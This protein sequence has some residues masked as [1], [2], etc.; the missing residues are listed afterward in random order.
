MSKDLYAILGVSKNSSQDEIKK[1]Y[2]KIAMKYHPDRNP[3]NKE[4]EAKF[5]EA[6]EAYETLSNPEKKQYYDTYGTTEGQN[7]GFGGGSP[8][9]GSGFEDIF[10]QFFGGGSPFGSSGGQ[11]RSRSMS[12]DGS[13][14][15]FSLSITLEEA[16]NGV[17]KKVS[18]NGNVGCKTCDGIGGKGI[19]TC[20]ICKGSG[21]IRQQRGFFI[22]ESTC[23]A[24]HGNGQTISNKCKDCDGDGRKV[25]NRTIEVKVMQGIKDGQKILLQEQGDAG[26]YGGKNGDLYILVNIQ[27]HKIFT[28]IENDIHFNITIPF[29]D[30]I[31]G[32]EIE[33]PTIDGKYEKVTISAGTQSDSEI[34]VKNK[35]VNRLNASGM[36]GN[37]ILKTKIETPV[38]LNKK[39]KELIEEFRTQSTE[40]NSPNS[41]GFFD[42]IKNIFS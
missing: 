3:N 23:H 32:T 7:Q 29:A 17:T 22:T 27:K 13:D 1:A 16:H 40:K 15:Q 6:A 42:K 12:V 10:N 41:K 8:F 19:N 36:R 9:G 28:R 11:R 38:N 35:G 26:A 21:V 24:C 31:L 25:S 5:K 18:F 14:L 20:G 30:A 37:M 33:V 39:Q 2:R 4:A 34:T